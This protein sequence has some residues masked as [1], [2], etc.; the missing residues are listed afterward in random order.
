[1]RV[2]LVTP[3]YNQAE[4]LGAT[5]ESVLAQDHPD[6]EYLVIDDGS[7]DDSLALAR[8]YEAAHPGRL[9]VL[10]QANAGQAATLNR[11]WSLASGALLGYLSSDDCLNPGAITRLVQALETRPDAV[12]AYPDFELIDA[13]GIVLRAVQAEDFDAYRLQVELVCQ[14]GPGALFR[15]S[16]FER[17]GG[18]RPGLRQT[19]D[20]EFW[21]RVSGHGPFLRVP[22]LLAQYRIHE[23]SA[24]FRVMPVERAEEIVQMVATTAQAL[25]LPNRD[26]RRALARALSFAAKNHAQSGRLLQSLNR[27]GAALRLRPT[28]L[29]DGAMWRAV[30]GGLLRRWRYQ[31]RARL[32]RT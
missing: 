22:Q 26:A 5:I 30:L 19:P 15:R 13:A 3:V 14:P 32:V 21:L 9:R 17:E 6:L 20:F 23:E 1:M 16:V 12:V 31:R 2:S 8:R 7:S 29:W 4:Y 25:R 28:L 27:V 10:T 11:G 24:S 18:W